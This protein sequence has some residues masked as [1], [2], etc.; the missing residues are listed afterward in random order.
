MNLTEKNKKHIDSMS[1][2]ALLSGWRFAPVG[3]TWFQGE[4]GDY[5]AQRMKELRDQGVDH[6]GAS[7]ELG[8]EK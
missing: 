5:W 2:A 7:K 4:T 1:Y 6:V 8:W 3:D